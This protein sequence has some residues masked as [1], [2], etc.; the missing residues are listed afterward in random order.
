MIADGKA[1]PVPS[2]PSDTHPFFLMMR[3]VIFVQ[4]SEYVKE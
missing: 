3:K 1:F 4:I 2:D